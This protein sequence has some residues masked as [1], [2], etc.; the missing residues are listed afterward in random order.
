[1]TETQSGLWYMIKSEGK[2]SNFTD[3]DKVVTGI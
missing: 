1:M 2:G 3:K